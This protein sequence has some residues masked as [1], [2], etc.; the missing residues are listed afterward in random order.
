MTRPSVQQLWVAPELAALAVL[1]VA[2]DTA[3]LAL[4]AVYPETHDLDNHDDYPELR[5]ALDLIDT[6]RAVAACLNRYKL[7]LLLAQERDNLLPF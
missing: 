4:A 3:V 7:A 6:A 5:A 2:A 1:E